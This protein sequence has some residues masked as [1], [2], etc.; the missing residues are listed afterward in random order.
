MI[1]FLKW[2]FSPEQ[3]IAR[4]LRKAQSIAGE[5]SYTVAFGEFS[6][7]ARAFERLPNE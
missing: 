1:K 5:T 3:R 7:L 2:Y 6:D 4:L